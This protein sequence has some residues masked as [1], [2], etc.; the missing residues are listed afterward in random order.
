M[1]LPFFA[2]SRDCGEAGPLRV[3]RLPNKRGMDKAHPGLPVTG[4]YTAKDQKKW[5]RA[6]RMIARGSARSSSQRYA[7]AVGA[8]AN[9]GTY[10]A[11]EVVFISAEGNRRGRLDPDFAEIDRAI[12]AGAL[13]ITDTPAD[14]M[15]PYNIGERQ[16]AAHL[17][18]AGY[19]QDASG[20]WRRP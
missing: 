17:S 9:S 14:R 5:D 15:R 20:V 11:G 8:L 7:E 12:A 16:V 19:T 13:F 10:A 1:V 2:F 3:H 6:Q 4:P 18:R